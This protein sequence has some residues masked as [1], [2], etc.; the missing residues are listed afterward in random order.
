MDHA[1][2]A[3]FF[4]VINNNAV[5][6]VQH[7]LTACSNH[8]CIWYRFEAF[9]SLPLFCTKTSRNTKYTCTSS[10]IRIK[11]KRNIIVRFAFVATYTCD[12]GNVYYLRGSFHK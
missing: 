11:L 2:Y 10:Q 3:A 12:F 1:V 5:K 6:G 9:P 8:I 4:E 7:S